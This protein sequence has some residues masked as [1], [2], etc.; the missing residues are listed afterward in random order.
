MS[1]K[2]TRAGAEKPMRIEPEKLL[3]WREV[4]QKRQFDIAYEAKV[5][6]SLI[7]LL[8]AGKA[9]DVKLSTLGRICRALKVRPN[10]LLTDPE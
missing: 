10:D 1:T 9:G 7:S 6:A 2:K 5:S 8:E 4:R 3:H